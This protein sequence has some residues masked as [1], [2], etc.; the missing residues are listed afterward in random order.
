MERREFLK[1]G[2]VAGA[3]VAA[4]GCATGSAKAP[5]VAASEPMAPFAPE[6]I[7]YLTSGIDRVLAGME[8]ANLAHE[9]VPADLPV[10]RDDKDEMAQVESLLQK[11][12]RSLYVSG[13]F[14]DQPQAVRAC[15]ELQQRVIDNLP[16]MDEAIR[17]STTVLAGL[18]QVDGKQFQQALHAHPEIGMRVAEVLDGRASE[19]GISRKRRMQLRLAAAQITT[20]LRHQHPAVLA[21]EYLVKTN[22]AYVRHGGSELLRKVAARTGEQMF[23]APVAAAEGA[24]SGTTYAPIEPYAPPSGPPPATPAPAPPSAPNVA[25]PGRAAP[26][27]PPIEQ[28]PRMGPAESPAPAAPVEQ[29]KPGSRALSAAGWMFGIGLGAFFGGLLIVELGAFPGVFAMTVGVLLVLAAIVT[30]L[31]GL[32]IRAA[33]R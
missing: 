5:A 24:A 25:F 22:K 14:L 27:Y 12:I 23:W 32:I 9:L 29:R 11:G 33:S 1:A 7:G 18:T 8:K 10:P 17:E 6:E 19:L 30:A 15:P 13:I 4:T 3:A 20:R 21:E 16:V 2:A 26:A 28:I 31:V